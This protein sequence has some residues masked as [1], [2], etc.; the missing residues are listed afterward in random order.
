MK[1][2]VVI[3]AVLFVLLVAFISYKWFV[4]KEKQWCKDTLYNIQKMVEDYFGTKAG[5]EKLEKTLVKINE[6]IDNR[7]SKLSKFSKWLLKKTLNEFII[8]KLLEE[9]MP[10]IN[11]YGFERK[12]KE[13]TK[14]AIDFGIQKGTELLIK[15]AY[16][17]D[18]GGNKELTHETRLISIAQELNVQ[19]KDK[20]FVG[21]YA[22]FETNFKEEKRLSAGITAGMKF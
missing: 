10:K 18:V 2:D 8:K 3:Y 1:I 5:Q 21:A 19:A 13:L 11:K 20:G 22:E 17:H 4:K 16:N 15:E 12:E 6:I 14:A 9:N 7:C